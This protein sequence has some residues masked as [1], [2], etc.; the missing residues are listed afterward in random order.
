LTTPSILRLVRRAGWKAAILA[1]I[2]AGSLFLTPSTSAQPSPTIIVIGGTG[3]AQ[4]FRAQVGSTCTPGSPVQVF[5]ELTGSPPSGTLFGIAQ[6][7]FSPGGPGLPVAT[8]I[9]TAAPP[10]NCLGSGTQP[11]PPFLIPDCNRF[12]FGTGSWRVTCIF[13]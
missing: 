4:T 6:C 1:V 11:P 7:G 12:Y 5:A 8:C 13:Q 2:I 10:N 3:A 9:A